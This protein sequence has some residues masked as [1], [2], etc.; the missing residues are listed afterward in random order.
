MC[1]CEFFVCI[2]IITYIDIPLIKICSEIVITRLFLFPLSYP[3]ILPSLS[4]F[5]KLPY[6][7]STH[8]VGGT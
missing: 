6:L 1:V 2:L 7:E 5:F 4:L 8:S 3:V